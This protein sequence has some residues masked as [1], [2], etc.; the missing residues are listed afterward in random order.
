MTLIVFNMGATFFYISFSLYK[1]K[2]MW[3]AVGHDFELPVTDEEVAR[4]D[5][6]DLPIYTILVPLYHEANVVHRLVPA[7]ARL[8]YPV[9]KLDVKLLVEEDDIDTR[10]ALTGTD[11][12][13]HIRVLVVP[14]AE[15]KTKPKACNYGLLHALG[16]YVVIYDAEDRP[17]PDQLKKVV[18]AF[19]K[20]DKAVACIQC[21]LSYFNR[22]Q[23]L[24]TRWFT[25]EYCTW[26][27]LLMP[28][29]DASE[30][31]IPLGGTSN[32]LNRDRLVEL[33]AWDP[34]NVTED[35]DLGLRLHRAGWRTAIVDSTTFEEANSD[36]NNWVRQRSRWVKGYMQTWLVHM[37][38]PLRLRRQIGTWSWISFQLVV[39]GTFIGFLLNPI[40][41]L[42]TTLWVLTH[43]GLIKTVFPS[44]IFYPAAVGLYVGNFVFMYVNVAGALRR[45]YFGLVKYALLSPLYWALMSIGA[46]K[47]LIQLIRRPHYWEKT[48]HGLDVEATS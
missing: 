1:F 30:S 16:R 32:H 5:D 47:G 42:L 25:L 24:L 6:D 44:I 8:D 38:Q 29:L 34:F 48:I 12:P 35:C 14:H 21:K 18:V 15:P 20:A 36:L 40:Y 19:S 41:W 23:N 27:D 45:Q 22:T 43:F 11:L 39:A 7:L 37:R 31:P 3:D 9:S 13:P 17:D 46:W 2:M 26:F 4:L 10:A 28:G 33:G